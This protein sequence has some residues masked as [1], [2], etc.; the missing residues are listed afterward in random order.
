MSERL[1]GRDRA[2]LCLA[3]EC[4]RALRKRQAFDAVMT[5]FWYASP[6]GVAHEIRDAMIDA[7]GLRDLC[8]YVSDRDLRLGRARLALL[9]RAMLRADAGDYGRFSRHG[10]EW[11]VTGRSCSNTRHYVE[12][13]TMRCDAN[14]CGCYEKAIRRITPLWELARPHT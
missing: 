6:V 5:V 8:P 1:G 2:A 11:L 7:Y 4:L 9:F 14:S 10:G 3:L 12:P 13:N